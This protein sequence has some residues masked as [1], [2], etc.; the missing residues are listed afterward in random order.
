MLSKDD[1]RRLLYVKK[2]SL[3]FL[4]DLIMNSY[5]FS[6]VCNLYYRIKI[7]QFNSLKISS[8]ANFFRY[9]FGRSYQCLNVFFLFK[10]YSI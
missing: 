4:I 9:D 6:Y 3:M 7:N 1:F 10:L 5:G 2:K 8:T